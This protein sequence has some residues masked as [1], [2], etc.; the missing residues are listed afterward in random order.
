MELKDLVGKRFGRW[1][2]ESF[3]HRKDTKTRHYQY[4]NCI[5]NCGV[6][7]SVEGTSLKKGN[8]ISCGCYW[9]EN[10]LKGKES[11]RWKNDEIGYFAIHQWLR[12]N[13]RKAYMC[14]NR[15]CKGKSKQF[16]W[17]KLK[18]K[19][20]KRK[21]ENFWQLCRS[22]HFIYDGLSKNLTNSPTWS[23]LKK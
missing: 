8:S 22:C 15:K 12:K 5:C 17:S 10:A 6:K 19:T 9:V 1:K 23:R 2:V 7:R 14:E 16:Q 13:Y 3:S 20:Y 21:R 11:G 4:W 18:G